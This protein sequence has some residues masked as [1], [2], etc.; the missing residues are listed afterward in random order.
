MEN[1]HKGQPSGD[2]LIRHNVNGIGLGSFFGYPQPLRTI[3]CCPFVSGQKE[4]K[5]LL[6]GLEYENTCPGYTLNKFQTG[7]GIRKSLQGILEAHHEKRHGMTP[8]EV[9]MCGYV[10]G[11]VTMLIREMGMRIKAPDRKGGGFGIRGKECLE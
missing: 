3:R 7:I 8:S 6:M 5:V 10:L 1:L 4:L 2:F 11:I 9:W